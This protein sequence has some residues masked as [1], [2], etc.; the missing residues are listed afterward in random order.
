MRNIRNFATGSTVFSHPFLLFGGGI[1]NLDSGNQEVKYQELRNSGNQ[2]KAKENQ[3]RLT[4]IAV[5]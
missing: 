4:A 5:S 2:E 1:Q 3:D